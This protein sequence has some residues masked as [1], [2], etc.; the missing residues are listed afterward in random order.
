MI[1]YNLSRYPDMEAEDVYKLLY[2]GCMG[3]GH[4]GMNKKKFFD[5]LEE[6]ADSMDADWGGD[7]VIVE[8]LAGEYVRVH[9][10]PFLKAGGTIKEL[11]E[12]WSRSTLTPGNAGQFFT[13]LD[14]WAIEDAGAYGLEKFKTEMDSLSRRA[15]KIGHP[16]AIHHSEKYR[17]K[18]NPHYRVISW[19]ESLKLLDVLELKAM[20]E[21][22]K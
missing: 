3:P 16:P 14:A 4:L 10:R 9:L 7:T 21:S 11:A 18:Y 20:D 6:E 12:A 17:E 8:D 2:Q 19:E 5:Y 22:G 13:T 1:A 15:H